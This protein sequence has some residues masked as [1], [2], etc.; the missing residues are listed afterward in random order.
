MC[1]L[2]SA[3][4]NMVIFFFLLSFCGLFSC[5]VSVLSSYFSVVSRFTDLLL[6]LTLF[7][8]LPFPWAVRKVVLVG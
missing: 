6:V 8:Y 4:L 3:I 2:W 7:V 1:T 5:E